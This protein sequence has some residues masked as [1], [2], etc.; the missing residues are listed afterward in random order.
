MSEFKMLS[1]SQ[2]AKL[3]KLREDAE[4]ERKTKKFLSELRKIE[5][6]WKPWDPLKVG[7]PI[8]FSRDSVT[9]AGYITKVYSGQLSV[10]NIAFGIIDLYEISTPMGR[11]EEISLMELTRRTIE[12]VTQVEI[13]EKMKAVSTPELLRMLQQHRSGY[14]PYYHTATEFTKEQIKAELSLRPHISNKKERKAFKN[15]ERT[16]KKRRH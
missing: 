11:V 10:N 2:E 4:A 13:P 1:K 6:Q 9:I 14:V 7:D 3:S 12:D 8:F 5:E 15:H 16:N